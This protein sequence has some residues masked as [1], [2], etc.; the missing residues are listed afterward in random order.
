MTRDETRGQLAL[1][2]LHKYTE[3]Q[4]FFVSGDGKL[5]SKLYAL[6]ERRSKLIHEIGHLWSEIAEVDRKEHWTRAVPQVLHDTLESYQTECGIVA[7]EAF[8][9]RH[10]WTVTRPEAK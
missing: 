5:G 1:K 6:E 3:P 4:A 2:E 10:G 8:L 7:A 9:K